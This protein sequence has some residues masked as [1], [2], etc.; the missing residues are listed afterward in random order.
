M[1]IR[2]FTNRGS[3]TKV[4]GKFPS[5]KTGKTVWFESQLERDMIFLLEF[6]SDVVGYREQPLRIA[7]SLDGKRHSYTPDFL[8][9]RRLGQQI[10]E[11]KYEED[12]EKPENVRLFDAVA[13]VCRET[14]YEFV[15]A[16]ERNIRAQPRLDNIK[17]LHRYSRTPVEARYIVR[18]H[19]R[20]RRDSQTRLAD[21]FA[22]CEEGGVT[23]AV[24]YAL[25]YHGELGVDLMQPLVA[26]SLVSIPDATSG[27]KV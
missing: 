12:A 10:V 2:K 15:V 8:V 3:T 4:I 6:D 20:L 14:G 16:T 23:R 24:I 26:D 21:L 7:C 11:V 19:E 13:P 17:L 18:C 5:L 1:R 9:Q 22:C 27:R 25:I